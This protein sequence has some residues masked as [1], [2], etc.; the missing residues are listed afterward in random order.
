[1]MINYTYTIQKQMIQ[2]NYTNQ[3][4]STNTFVS[5]HIYNKT[6]VSILRDD[7]FL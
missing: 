5:K 4:I 7:N 2:V 3:F 6:V 1:M